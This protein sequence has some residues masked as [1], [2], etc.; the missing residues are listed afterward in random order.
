MS[1]YYGV[2]PHNI[3]FEYPNNNINFENSKVYINDKNQKIS[4]KNN[5][6]GVSAFGFSGTNTHLVLEGSY[7]NKKNVSSLS[8][9]LQGQRCCITDYLTYKKTPKSNESLDLKVQKIL[10]TIFGYHVNL[11]QSIYEMGG[12][13][14][15]AFEI[16]NQLNKSFKINISASMI[17]S[18]K[19][20]KEI[21]VKIRSEIENNKHKKILQLQPTKLKIK[22]LATPQYFMEQMIQQ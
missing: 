16:A 8:N 7:H 19:S 11:S 5:Y 6:I 15:T 21:I 22:Y 3:N 4:D 10:K 12:D 18:C 9:D 17:L 1:L 2:I 20:I 14:L 13:S